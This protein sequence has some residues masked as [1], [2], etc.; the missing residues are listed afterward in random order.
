MSY[1]KTGKFFKMKIE[2]LIS[3]STGLTPGARL[4]LGSLN[5]YISLSYK[6]AIFARLY[7]EL[8]ALRNVSFIYAML[9]IPHL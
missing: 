5:L 7:T 3:L 2:G 6:R 1:R 4:S 9:T 8:I